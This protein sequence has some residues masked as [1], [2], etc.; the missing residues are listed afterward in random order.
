M[1][2]FSAYLKTGEN[3]YREIFG[4]AFEDFKA[5]QVF[6]HRPGITVTQQDNKDEATET[7]NNAML[8]YDQHY[9]SQTEWKH[10]L[11][12]STLTLQKVL[13][14]TWK[15]FYKKLRVSVYHD[16][17]MTHPVFD[18][19]TLYAKSTIQSINPTDSQELGEVEVI[20]EAL[21]QNHVSVSKLHY[22]VLIYKRGQHPEEKAYPGH[23][24]PLTDEKFS[25]Y[26][27]CAANQSELMEQA[28]LCYEELEIGETYEHRPAKSIF[29]SEAWQHATRSLDWHPRYTD[30]EYMKLFH[31][32]KFPVSENYILGVTTALTTRTFDRVV[33]NLGWVN[34]QI[35]APVF[36]GDTL[37]TESVITA[38]R[39]SH[40]R[41]TQ[42]IMT[43]TTNAL[44]QH[45]Q[46]VL[47]Y[48]RTFLI[49]K[50]GLGPYEASGY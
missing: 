11:G 7:L 37:Y 41:P 28:G 2:Q 6:H 15:T 19:D 35:L 20:T 23:F 25:A 4:L 9:A 43:A 32:G 40:S 17:A 26:H 45:Q 29:E 14:S 24:A 48:E 36:V 1:S 42:G 16:I 8:H 50:K 18:G 46:K 33:A 13:G 5:G 27:P 3:R 39:E 12:V 34:A 22:T 49:Y 10:C 47:T 38:K 21:N 44:N 30:L 31:G